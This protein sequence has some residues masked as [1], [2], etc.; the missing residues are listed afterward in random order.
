MRHCHCVL[1]RRH[2]IRNSGEPVTSMLT[3]AEENVEKD[4][5]EGWGL[6]DDTETEW[7]FLTQLPGPTFGLRVTNPKILHLV[8][9]LSVLFL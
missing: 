8:S 9:W 2:G 3:P 7:L 1:E 4:S 6:W 5:G